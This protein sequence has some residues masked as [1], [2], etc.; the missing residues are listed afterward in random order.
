MEQSTPL[1]ES[2]NVAL[3]KLTASVG[4]E[5]VEFLAAQGPDVLNARVESSMQYET[6]LEGKAQNQVS[7]SM[8]TLFVAMP[9]EKAQ[10]LPLRVDVKHY[11]GKNKENLTLWIR[12]IEMDMTS[13][14]ISLEHQRSSLPSLRSMREQESGL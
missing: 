12:E 3:G 10:H 11:S 8:P 9:D 2:Q 4:P 6:A 14:L 7:S 5:Y 13:G 1:T